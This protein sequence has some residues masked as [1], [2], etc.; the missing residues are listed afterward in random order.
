MFSSEASVLGSMGNGYSFEVRYRK[1]EIQ[2]F[3][4]VRNRKVGI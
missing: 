1:L 2:I 3:L 4:R